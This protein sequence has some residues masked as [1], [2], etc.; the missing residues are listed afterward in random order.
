MSSW[1]VLLDK[2]VHER[3]LHLVLACTKL[4]FSSEILRLLMP[5]SLPRTSPPPM[6]LFSKIRDNDKAIVSVM[7]I[8][9]TILSNYL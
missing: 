1:P 2:D 7:I 3:M 9:L 6:V 5:E 8:D 4:W